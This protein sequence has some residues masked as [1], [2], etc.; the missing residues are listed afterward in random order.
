MGDALAVVLGALIAL[1]SSLLV[2]WRTSR[3][4][5]RHRWDEARLAAVGDFINASN[6]AI[7]ALFDEGRS[8]GED[9]DDLEVRDRVARQ[10]MDAVR[11]AHARAQ[12]M[13]ASERPVLD[14]Y[15]S[16]LNELKALADGGFRDG[17]ERWKV[18]QRRLQDDHEHLIVATSHVLHIPS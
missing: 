18:L 2:E 3:R 17:D 15:R 10:A 14:S 6:T 5:L 9:R 4:A 13:L 8:R 1:A 16:S 12:L 7:G 11:V